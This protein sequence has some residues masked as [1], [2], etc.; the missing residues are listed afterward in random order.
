[1]AVDIAELDAHEQ[2]SDEL[3][4]MWK[5]YS[6]ADQ[7]DLLQ[8]PDID[9][10]SS[11]EKVAEFRVAGSIPADRLNQSFQNLLAGTG[12][13]VRVEEDAPIYFHP[14]LPGSYLL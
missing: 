5:S 7:K 11:P 6:R 14:L 10:L 2:P 12:A 3:K 4:G 8:G 9:D 1:M 13:E